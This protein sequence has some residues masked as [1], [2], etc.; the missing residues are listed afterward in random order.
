MSTPTHLIVEIPSPQGGR[1]AGI[2]PGE[3]LAVGR[4]DRA[5]L[6]IPG[7]PR[8]AA[9]HFE[10]VWDG[11]QA[12]LHDLGGG[13]IVVS[14]E[15][16]AEAPLGHGTWVR[17][18]S[19]DFR[20]WVEGRVRPRPEDADP[21]V[22]EDDED[23]VAAR[24]LLERDRENERAYRRRIGAALTELSRAEK[25]HAVLDGARDERV[26]EVLAA[27][28]DTYASL[29][30]GAQGQAQGELAPYLVRFAPGSPL[31]TRIAELGWGRRWGIFFTVNQPFKEIRRHLRRL[32]MVDDEETG[33]RLYFRFYDPEVLRVVLPTLSLRQ[34]TELWGDIDA[35]LFEDR[36][37][38]MER[39]RRQA[40][41]TAAKERG[42]AS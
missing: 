4:S 31:I 33:E 11:S 40:A 15:I 29:F 30:D 6:A 9:F 22:D 19:T 23:E 39:R 21:P 18:G 42:E 13:E 41:L 16:V 5:G 28:L 25:L 3:K 36:E 12:R 1:K 20:I 32:L 37:G 2:L 7:D 24:E 26:P 27:S 17:A 8:L 14:G 35:F 34:A 38:T 10:V